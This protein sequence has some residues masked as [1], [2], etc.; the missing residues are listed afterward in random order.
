MNFVHVKYHW[1]RLHSIQK[2]KNKK[3]L[4]ALSIPFSTHTL[5]S[6]SDFIANQ[7]RKTLA[8]NQWP[9][10]LGLLVP[11]SSPPPVVSVQ[12][13]EPPSGNISSSDDSTPRT[14]ATTITNPTWPNP[15]WRIDLFPDGVA[16]LHSVSLWVLLFLTIFAT[17]GGL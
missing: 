9:H 5:H 4:V 10:Q 6:F 13:T 15:T 8:C 14:R 11:V 1:R 2:I 12:T 7:L 3:L 17:L 16:S